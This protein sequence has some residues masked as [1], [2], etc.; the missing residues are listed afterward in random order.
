MPEKGVD[1]LIRS[2][3][4]TDSA[5]LIVAGD[6][7][8]RSRLEDMALRLAPG[9]TQF[10]GSLT[11]TLPVYQASDAL[12]LASKGGDSMPA[13][14]AEAAFC[15]LPTIATDVGAIGE[16]I[17]HNVTGIVT[18]RGD[19]TALQSAIKAAT[20]NRLALPEM[21]H[22]AMALCLEQFEINPVADMWLALLQEVG[23]A[24]QNTC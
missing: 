2:I 6:G 19:L 9:R 22:A 23:L 16:M 12:L 18:R 5:K 21:G 14:I 24:A 4:D 17:D 7:P 1:L 13:V 20:H 11:D 8:E 15:S 10:V 3:A